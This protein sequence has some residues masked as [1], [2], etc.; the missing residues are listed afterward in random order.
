M[1]VF[2]TAISERRHSIPLTKSNRWVEVVQHFSY[3]V[4]DT[5]QKAYIDIASSDSQGVPKSGNII[6][7]FSPPDSVRLQGFEEVFR[8]GGFTQEFP[9]LNLNQAYLRSKF[10]VFVEP[11][12]MRP[13]A[14]LPQSSGS[15]TLKNGTE[16]NH[17]MLKFD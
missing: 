13:V 6:F 14:I 1:E 8:K 11:D 4:V 2:K 16:I 5:F 15:Y 12:Q 9:V 17:I 10:A 7:E 3:V